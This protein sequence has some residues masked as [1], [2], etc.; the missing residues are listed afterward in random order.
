M[1]AGAR[2]NSDN[3]IDLKVVDRHGNPVSADRLFH[4]GE[5][6]AYTVR[7]A[8]GY[9]VTGTAESPAVV[10]GRCRW[11]SNSPMEA[12]RGDTRGR[13]RRHTEDT[14]DRAGTR[15]LAGARWKRSCWSAF[16][17]EGFVSD[18]RAGFNNLDRDYY[19]MVVAAYDAVVG[20]ARYVYE[21]TIASGSRLLE[22]DVQNTDA[23]CGKS[24]LG[25][26]VG[27]R[28]A[29]KLV[30]E[31]LW[32]VRRP[33]SNAPSCRRLF[34]GDGSC[35]ALPRNTIQ[36]SYSTRSSRLAADVQQSDAGI[37]E[38][39][40]GGPGLVPNWSSRHSGARAAARRILR[41]ANRFRW[42]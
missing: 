19:A 33:R 3:A 11:S 42:S 10:P 34:E 23:G 12:D 7:T 32:R 39:F 38:S 36:V 21:R 2:S 31:W 35:S 28:S 14:A 30:P 20:G 5:H 6:Q 1:V 13:S 4:S 37:A 29:D 40:L 41:C 24:C 27:Q 15:R 25:E 9:E 16:I 18:R 17:S 22:L 8:E 26:L